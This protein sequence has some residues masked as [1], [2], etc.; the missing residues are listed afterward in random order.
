MPVKNRLKKGSCRKLDYVNYEP[1]SK[2]CSKKCEK[3]YENNFN[4]ERKIEREREAEEARQ[5]EEYRQ[6]KKDIK[7]EIIAA[8]F[9]PG[10]NVVFFGDED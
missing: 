3:A 1:I 6:A 10:I 4:E 5:A 7:K 9:E 8:G 2:F